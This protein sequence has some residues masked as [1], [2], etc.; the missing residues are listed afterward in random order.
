MIDKLTVFDIVTTA[1]EGTDKYLV[2]LKITPDN[3]IYIS[4]DGDNGVIIDDCVELS[5]A[6][7]SQLNREV[8][9]YELNV[10]SAG[11]DSPL[12]NAR[13]YRKNMGQEVTVTLMTGDK[14]QG[15]L[16]EADDQHFVVTIPSTKR[17][18]EHD[19][20]FAYK[21]IKATKIVIKF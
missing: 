9:D 15:I 20:S 12:R 13:Q 16:K 6:V 14:Y 1:L 19:E 21:D 8:E 17:T 5:R 11:L 10:A 2:D 7:E 3:R 18:P 4:I